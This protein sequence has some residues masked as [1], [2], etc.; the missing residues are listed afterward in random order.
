MEYFQSME[1][2]SGDI[3]PRVNGV[4]EVQIREARNLLTDIQGAIRAFMRDTPFDFSF[5][6]F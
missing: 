4:S 2:S 5:K 6:V 3:E 1:S